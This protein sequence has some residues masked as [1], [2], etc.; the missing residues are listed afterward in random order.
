MTGLRDF[1]VDDAIEVLFG[2]EVV[3]AMKNNLD[4]VFYKELMDGLF[5]VG[6]VLVELIDA[7]GVFATPFP[8]GGSFNTATIVLVCAADEVMDKNESIFRFTGCEDLF[9]PFVLGFT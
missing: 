3:V 1:L 4:T 9:K 5:P 7:V 6:T 8:V 2:E